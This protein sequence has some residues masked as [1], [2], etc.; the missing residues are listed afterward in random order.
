MASNPL[1]YGG[2]IGAPGQYAA[3]GM[4]GPNEFVAPLSGDLTAISFRF[5]N[6][7]FTSIKQL[8]TQVAALQQRLTAAGL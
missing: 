7:L 6:S 3:Q 2:T 8:E 5:L 4:I 1:P